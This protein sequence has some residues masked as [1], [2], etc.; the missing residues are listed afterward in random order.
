MVDLYQVA[1][2]VR[3]ASNPNLTWLFHPTLVVMELTTGISFDALIG[4]DIIRTCKLFVDGPAGQFT[5][6]R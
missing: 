2:H 5:L 6:D 1:L 3:D 4:L